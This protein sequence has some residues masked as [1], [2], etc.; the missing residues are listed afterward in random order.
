M[1]VPDLVVSGFGF[2]VL[3]YTTLTACHFVIQL[4]YAHRTHRLQRNPA[5]ADRFPANALDVDV[6]VPVYNETPSDLRACTDSILAQRHLGLVNLI[7]VDDGS[8]N[9]QQLM[10]IYE[11]LR[12]SGATVIMAAQNRGKREA[13]YLGFQALRG[14]IVVTVDSDTRLDP[15]AVATITRQF[16]DPRIGGVTGDV[17]VTNVRR[18]LLTRLIEVRY[19]MAFHQERAA[20]S[21]FRTVLCCSGP[22]SAYRRSVIE[23]LMEKFV[24][25]SFRG[26]KCTYGDDRHLSN[27]ILARDFDTVFDEGAHATT[28]VPETIPT[29]LRQQL[30]WN[31]SFYRELLWTRPFLPRRSWYI[32]FDLLVQTVL[33]ALLIVSIAAAL[34]YSAAFSPLHLVRYAM[35]VTAIGLVRTTYAVIRERRLEFYLFLLYGFVHASLLVPLRAIALGTLTDNRWGTRDLIIESRGRAGLLGMVLGDAVNRGSDAASTELT[36][37]AEL[38]PAALSTTEPQPS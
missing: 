31:K 6:I 23:P 15:D 38:A 19:W 11:E 1:N 25:Q 14:E 29:Y 8:R 36:P 12:Q 28:N 30:R 2:V 22:L 33:P 34:I 18:N 13:Q 27:L 17:R 7:V 9:R 37:V 5:F 10:P 3:L 20:Q 21:W 26:V 32:R 24:S 35:A 4:V 16:I